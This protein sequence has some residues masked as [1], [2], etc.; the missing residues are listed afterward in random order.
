MN[1]HEAAHKAFPI[2]KG[3]TRRDA[4]S[5]ISVIRISDGE[6]C[7]LRLEAGEI[8]PGWQPTPEDLLAN[9]WEVTE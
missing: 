1:L 8:V 4:F 5:D 9:D 2:E 3:I 6:P 7:A